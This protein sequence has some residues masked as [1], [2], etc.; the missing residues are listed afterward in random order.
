MRTS[1]PQA[2]RPM[3]TV[4]DVM[5]HLQCS[6]ASVYRLLKRPGCPCV[7]LSTKFYRIPRE[8]F[9]R[10]LEAQPGTTQMSA[11]RALKQARSH[12]PEAPHV[13]EKAGNGTTPRAV[14]RMP[15][16]D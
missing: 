15:R 16:G 8:A 1:Q 2:D 13:W 4:R 10:W 9:L 3:W 5:D 7:I 14:I 6:K 11:A 12:P